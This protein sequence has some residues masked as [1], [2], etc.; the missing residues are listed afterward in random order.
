MTNQLTLT[1]GRTVDRGQEITVLDPAVG[2]RRRFRL[3]RVETNGDVTCW[4]PVDSGG[5]TPNGQTRS[6]KPCQVEDV[7]HRKPRSRTLR[8]QDD[9][10]TPTPVLDTDGEVAAT[11]TTPAYTVHQDGT[12]TIAGADPWRDPAGNWHRAQGDDA[13]YVP[14][15]N[16]AAGKVQRALTQGGA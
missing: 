13:T 5:L 12:V 11:A 9:T 8:E 7:K 6:F 3:M 2:Q 1:S 10:T 16:S 14:S 15:R 4:G